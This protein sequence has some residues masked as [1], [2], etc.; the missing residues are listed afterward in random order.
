MVVDAGRRVPGQQD[1]H[2]ALAGGS[3]A[4]QERAPGPGQG[5]VHGD[6]ADLVVAAGQF[7]GG[8]G[9]CLRELLPDGGDQNSAV[10]PRPGR[11]MIGSAA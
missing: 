3:R 6:D 1:R 9:G 4:G 2:A 5:R 10:R 7:G 8:A 11:G